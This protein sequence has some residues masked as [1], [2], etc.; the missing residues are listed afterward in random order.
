[1]RGWAEELL[2]LERMDFE[3]ARCSG[4]ND[5]GPWM[6]QRA[7]LLESL[8]A[9]PLDQAGPNARVRLAQAQSRG[10]ELEAKWKAMRAQAQTEAG[11]L[12]ASQLLLRTLQP[13]RRAP[14]VNLES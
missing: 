5:A 10:E 4:P 3:L 6:D 9:L 7:R 14:H 13:G 8:A 12:Y 11:N 2:E 1:M